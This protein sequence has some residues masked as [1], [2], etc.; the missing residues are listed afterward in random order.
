MRSRTVLALAV[1][2]LAA[3][4]LADA[5]LAIGPPVVPSFGLRARRAR[6]LDCFF[7]DYYTWHG[8]HYNSAWGAPVAVVTPPTV[9]MQTNWG[10]GVGNTRVARIRGQF[11]RDYP[12]RVS[13]NTGF[14]PTPAWPSDTTQ[15]GLYNVRGPW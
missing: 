1:L 6:Q 14:R 5:A 4:A 7:S 3:T 8:H 11:G 12:G 9:T 2:V 15:F 13:S 10:W